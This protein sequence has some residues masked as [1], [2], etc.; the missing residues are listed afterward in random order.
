MMILQFQ[1]HLDSLRSLG[2]RNKLF[3][4]LFSFYNDSPLLLGIKE[5]IITAGGENIP[6]VLIENEVKAAMVAIS[7][8]MVIGERRKFLALL[9][10]LK[11]EIDLETGVYNSL[12]F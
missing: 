3:Y 1:H 11:T 4:H 2:V 5:I 7:N 12:C 8:A 9:V 6:P 10:T